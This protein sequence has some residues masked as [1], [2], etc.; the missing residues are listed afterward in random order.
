[1]VL[2]VLAPDPKSPVQADVGTQVV[3]RIRVPV[4]SHRSPQDYSHA[5][6]FA[7]IVV[8]GGYRPDTQ[9]TKGSKVSRAEVLFSDY[10]YGQ[11]PEGPSPYIPFHAPVAPAVF[12]H[13][14]DEADASEAES[15]TDFLWT[16]LPTEAGTGRAHGGGGHGQT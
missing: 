3:A 6:L 9:A 12:Q 5:G 10:R 8:W 16:G 4:D 2:G 14:A 1:M 7:S 11:V 15:D 13:H